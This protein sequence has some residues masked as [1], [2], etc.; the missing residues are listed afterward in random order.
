MTFERLASFREALKQFTSAIRVD[1]GYLPA[2]IVDTNLAHFRLDAT[3]L[4]RVWTQKFRATSARSQP[5]SN[6]LVLSAFDKATSEVCSFVKK[7]TLWI[8]NRA[9]GVA[10]R[11]A[12]R[13]SVSYQNRAS[14][15][16]GANLSMSMV[17]LLAST[18]HV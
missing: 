17:Q 6:L 15:C 11:L 8:A 7:G 9:R 14:T 16:D 2:K 1:N 18:S 3:Q 12:L 10:G 4:E 5:P 13:G